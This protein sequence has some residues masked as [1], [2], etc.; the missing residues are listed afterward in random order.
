MVTPT[1]APLPRLLASGRQL[2]N[3]RVKDT[4]CAFRVAL[5][6]RAAS[7]SCSGIRTGPLTKE[8]TCGSVPFLHPLRTLS[9]ECKL[10]CLKFGTIFRLLLC[11]LKPMKKEFGL[12]ISYIRA[13]S[14]CKDKLSDCRSKTI[15][16]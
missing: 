10:T 14:F 2:V 11:P 12:I 6:C 7:E 3:Q 8:R 1:L 15:I 16:T 13:A 4:R 9:Y 5:A